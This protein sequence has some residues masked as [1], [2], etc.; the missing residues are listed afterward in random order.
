MLQKLYFGRCI[1]VHTDEKPL[2]DGHIMANMYWQ[3][4]RRHVDA[5]GCLC[6]AVVPRHVT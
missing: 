4:I 5:G 1:L 2:Y 3:T 6:V